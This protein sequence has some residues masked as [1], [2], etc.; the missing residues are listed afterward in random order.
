MDLRWLAYLSRRK[1]E[2]KNAWREERLSV[3][4]KVIDDDSLGSKKHFLSSWSGESFSI[5]R[6]FQQSEFTF[7]HISTSSCF[8]SWA[9]FSLTSKGAL[10]LWESWERSG[11]ITYHALVLL[12]LLSHEVFEVWVFVGHWWD[13]YLLVYP[14]LSTEGIC[15]EVYYLWCPKMM[16]RKE[17][18]SI[19]P[20]HISYHVLQELMITFIY[21]FSTI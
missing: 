5:D 4:N 8:F 10:R 15:A 2:E 14:S 13:W 3:G 6:R 21:L 7:F 16:V 1:I 17:R 19:T 12:L 20:Y 11:E 9:E 18:E